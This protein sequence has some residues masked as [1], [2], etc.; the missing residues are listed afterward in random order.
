MTEPDTSEHHPYTNSLIR[1]KSPY[2]LQ[3]AHNPVNWFPWGEEAFAKARKEDKPIFLS[4]G[5]STCHWCHVMAHE[6][7]ENPEIAKLMNDNFINI[8]VDREERPD[9]DLTY[10]TFV[11]ATTG[12]GGWPM[13]VWLTPDLKPILGGT[14]FP[15]EDLEGRPGFPSLLKQIT[16]LWKRRREKL[17]QQGQQIA[18]ALQKSAISFPNE[19]DASLPGAEVFDLALSQFVN[20]FD[21]RFGGFSA[22]PKFPNPAGLNLLFRIYAREGRKSKKAEQALAMAFFTLRAMAMGGVRDQLGGGFHRYSV[23]AYWH[24]P[25]FEKMLSDQAQLSVSYLEAYQISHDPF[26]AQVAKGTLDYMLH[27]LRGT[28][29]AFYSAED[30]DSFLDESRTKSIEGAFYLWSKEEINQLLAQQDAKIFHYAY[31]IVA[32]GHEL[33]DQNL[34]QKNVLFCAKTADLTAKALDL[35]LSEVEK[36]LAASRVILFQARKKRPRPHLDDKIITAWNGL[37]LS[38]FSKAAQILGD[39]HYLTAATTA[40]EF[41]KKHLYDADSGQLKR[42]YRNGPSEVNGFA[43]DYAYLIQGL[44]DLYE[45]SFESRWLEWAAELQE[46]LD[47]LYWDKEVGGYFSVSAE[48]HNSI[49]SIKEDYDSAEPAPNSVSALNLLRLS[50]ILNSNPLRERSEKIIRQAGKAMALSP[51][52]MSQIAIALDFLLGSSQQIVLGSDSKDTEGLQR[53]LQEVHWHF[54]PYKLLLGGGKVLG[55]KDWLASS[56]PMLQKMGAVNGEAAA[57]VCQNYTCKQPV[58]SPEELRNI[59]G[60]ASQ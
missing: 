37:A 29:G 55:E 14:Y 34:Q 11:Q 48:R 20:S 25:H 57:Y 31:R 8:K 22:A 16:K 6:S 21:S 33:S 24:V 46:K 35:P 26:F 30:A 49:L 60:E 59:L 43:S 50:R 27:D 3:H 41:L 32:V 17:V 18:E 52:P 38:A 1:E 39:Q 19:K 15:P 23:D 10:M 45:A 40:A 56:V 58:T 5:Y 47:S 51:L 28:E 7:F 12:S 2:L 13:S 44:L 54:L 53:L 42:S 36:S 9:V 4:I